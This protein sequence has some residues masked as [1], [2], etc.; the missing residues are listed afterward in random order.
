[1]PLAIPEPAARELETDPA[2]HPGP[3]VRR[4]ASRLERAAVRSRRAPSTG[5]AHRTP[6]ATAR[7]PAHRV[8]LEIAPPTG[9]AWVPALLYI[10][11]LLGR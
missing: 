8:Q 2:P 5:H 4:C 7:Q 1:M 11:Q 9:G 3:P 10:T 6:S